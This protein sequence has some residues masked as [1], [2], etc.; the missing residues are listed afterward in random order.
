KANALPGE[1][2]LVHGASGG[3]GL[4]AVQLARAAGLTVIG[5]GGTDAGRRLAAENGAHHVLDHGKD[6]YL[7]EVMKI[8][9]D[10]G[11]DVIVELLANVNLGKDLEVLAAGGRVAI[12]GSRGTVTIDPRHAMAKEGT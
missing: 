1:I 5:T 8:T 11:V 6:G 7:Q 12:I 10:R 3:V 2:I 9:E 4:A